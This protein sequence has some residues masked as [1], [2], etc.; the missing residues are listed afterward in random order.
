M[1]FYVWISFF[2]CCFPLPAHEINN[3]HAHVQLEEKAE[4]CLFEV[5]RLKLY[6]LVAG[7]WTVLGVSNLRLYRHDT[8]KKRRVVSRNETSG[9]L[10]LNAPLFPLV[11]AGVQKKDVTFNVVM[12]KEGSDETEMKTF[13]FR[14]T[15]EKTAQELKDAIEK[16]KEDE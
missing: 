3:S 10:L 2:L 4:T 6:E 7:A 8:T 12:K 5:D 1:H 11:K 9:K 14:T 16:Y 13:M 15:S